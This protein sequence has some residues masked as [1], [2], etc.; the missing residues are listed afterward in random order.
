M[1]RPSS[2]GL[3]T[4]RKAP[5][6]PR[7]THREAGN[8]LLLVH[9]SAELYG[10]DRVFLESVR[11]LT[12]AG[13]RVVVVLPEHGPLADHLRR[14]GARVL[15]RRTAVLR[16]S[17]LSPRGM[18]TFLLDCLTSLPGTLRLL[19]HR[20]DAVYISTITVP[21]WTLSAAALGH[22]VVTH[23]H[24]AE[25]TPPL[26]VR[27]GLALPLLACREVVVNSRAAANALHRS[28][29]PL[30]NRTKVVYNG[31]PGPDPAPEAPSERPRRLVLVGR[32]SPRKGTDTAVRATALLRERGHPVTLDLVGSVFNGYEWFE[33]EVRELI[34][35]LGL[36]DAVALHGF[37]SAVWHHYARADIALVPSR[38]EPFG[39]TAV[40]A[41][42]AGVPV[43]VTD[44]Q[45]LPETVGDG[46]RGHIVAADDPEALAD[47]IERLLR[48]WSSATERAEHARREAAELFDPARYH[49]SIRE[50]LV[51]PDH[52]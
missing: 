37:D 7:P 30:R 41:Q 8:P 43:V 20:F 35:E 46:R 28:I 9:P 17:V 11:A 25:E 39:N 5:A 26:P 6:E 51:G 49:D 24:E 22:R 32:L 47:G 50:L 16:K 2:K 48:D 33:R 10:S 44:V 40:E 23:V 36:P 3:P 13:R 1:I 4:S 38:F 21:V 45:G 18:L 27:A 15:H 42:L 19:R 34:A 31:V 29:P 52:R 12:S 14:S